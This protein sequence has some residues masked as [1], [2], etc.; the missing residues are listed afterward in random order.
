MSLLPA[1]LYGGLL[2][3]LRIGPVLAFAPPFS[4]IRIPRTFRVLLSLGLATALISSRPQALA[5][6][7]LAPGALVQAA[8]RELM[9]GIFFLTIFQAAFGAIYLAGRTI[10]LQAGFG[11]AVLID[12]TSNA[13]TP[14]IGTMLAMLGGMLFFAAGGQYELV[15]IIAASLDT[16]PL[17][18]GVLHLSP[19]P[20]IELLSAASIVA[21]GAVGA[22]IL[23]LFLADVAVGLL[24]RT[25]PQMNVLVLGVQVKTIVLLLVLG[26]SLGLTSAL[27]LRV[28]RLAL[29]SLSGLF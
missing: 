21:M 19:V 2:L 14:L 29:G 11:L 22:V 23:T 4:L 18:T 20:V 27:L 10:D 9:I 3:G 5:S 17:G 15:R 24:S 26:P 12:P 7:D 25:V 13:S 8:A 6:L 16:V 28:M 1:E